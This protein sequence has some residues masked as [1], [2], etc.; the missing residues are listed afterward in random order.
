MFVFL[1]YI[2]ERRTNG[3]QFS[4][5]NLTFHSFVALYCKC[6]IVCFS[7]SFSKIKLWSSESKYQILESF[8]QKNPLNSYPTPDHLQTITGL[9]CSQAPSLIY[10]KAALFSFC[11]SFFMKTK[12]H[13]TRVSI[14]KPCEKSPSHTDRT[15]T[16]SWSNSAF[17]CR[18]EKKGEK[19]PLFWRG[20]HQS[21]STHDGDVL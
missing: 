20:K 15:P 7:Y 1:I 21:G 12:K 4:L 19:I 6:K 9:R 10:A 16:P 17:W 13:Q 5:F 14:L 8:K 18:P 11:L 3:K 2:D